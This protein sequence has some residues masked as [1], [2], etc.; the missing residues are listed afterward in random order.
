[1]AD[2]VLILEN[3]YYSVISP[4]GCA[5]ILWRDN[6]QAPKA[7]AA[8]KMTSP[9]LLQLGLVDEMIVE[10]TG[11]AHHSWD[12]AAEAVKSAV[13]R[14]IGELRK[15]SV[16]DLGEGRYAKFRAFGEFTEAA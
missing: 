12:D 2:R 3:A 5:A 15:L 11:G 7:A 4:E 8:L 13:L 6:S 9:D 14:H 10:P 1:M 16:E